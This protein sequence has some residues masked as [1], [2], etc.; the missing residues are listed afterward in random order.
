MKIRGVIESGVLIRQDI[1]YDCIKC[2]KPVAIAINSAVVMTNHLFQDMASGQLCLD[3]HC[4]AVVP[5]LAE[6]ML[7]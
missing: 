5:K 7:S 2:G 1:D 4:D 3:C 6:V